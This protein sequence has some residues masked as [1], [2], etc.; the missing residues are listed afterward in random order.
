MT[1]TKKP[2]GFAALSPE[3]R[4]EIA[5]K[6]GSAQHTTRGFSDPEVASRAGKL[7]AAAKNKGKG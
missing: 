7:G 3:R 6:G 2:R 4:L 1:E 5:R